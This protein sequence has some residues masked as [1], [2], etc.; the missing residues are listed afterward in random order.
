MHMYIERKGGGGGNQ[1]KRPSNSPDYDSTVYSY[2]SIEEGCH[3]KQYQPRNKTRPKPRWNVAEF[4]TTYNLTYTH[5]LNK[6]VC[7]RT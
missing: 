4:I 2:M 1:T 5:T 3:G 6:K 7:T